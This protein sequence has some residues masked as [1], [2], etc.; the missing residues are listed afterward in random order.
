MEENKVVEMEVKE[1]KTETGETAVVAQP[2]EGL[3]SK[4]KK[5]WIW[6]NRG[7]VGAGLGAA[8]GFVGAMLLGSKGN[9]DTGEGPTE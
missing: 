7:K 4:F 2:K 5:T 9:S 6:R 8:A 3:V 1:Q